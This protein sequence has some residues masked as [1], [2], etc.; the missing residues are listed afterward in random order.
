MSPVRRAMV[1]AAGLGTRLLP[2]TRDV[3]KPALP[4]VGVPILGRVLDGLAEAGVEEAVVNLHHAPDSIRAVVAARGSALPRVRF[5]DE[6]AL[7]LGSAGALVPPRA[8]LEEAGEFLLVNADC[9][10]AVDYEAAV[11][12][13]RA[14]GASATL[15]SRARGEAPFRAL[16]V[17]GEGR[18]VR[19]GDE[20]RGLPGERHFLSVQVVSSRLLEHLPAEPRP[21]STFVD[22]Y[23]RAAEAGHVFRVVESDAEWHGLDSRELYLDA[24]RDWLA[25]RGRA[26]WIAAQAAVGAGA[27]LERGSAVHAGA[28]VGA[29]ARLSGTVLL[30]GA[31]VGAGA[32]VEDCLLG[33]DAVV[34]AEGRA[35]GRIVASGTEAA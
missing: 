2:L 28:R 24:T 23:P 21:L 32:V 1:L 20:V 14:T 26:S 3:A 33:P 17:D 34:P 6:T 19:W 25:R 30:P 11:R 15:V 16:V 10:H 29:G 9:V 4:F 27:V 12:S 18:I 31:V 35:S 5:S 22:W 7:L 13:H 8:W